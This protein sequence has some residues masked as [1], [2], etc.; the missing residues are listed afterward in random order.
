MAPHAVQ[1]DSGDIGK[2][3]FAEEAWDVTGVEWIPLDYE[4]SRLIF[5]PA[6][7]GVKRKR[8]D[9]TKDTGEIMIRDVRFTVKGSDFASCF[10]F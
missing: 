5:I 7:P 8:A 4:Q 6:F 10:V 1:T 3:F 9:G 2:N